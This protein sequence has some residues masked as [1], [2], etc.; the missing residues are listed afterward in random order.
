[1]EGKGR[2]YLVR[3][4]WEWW[5]ETRRAGLLSPLYYEASVSFRPVRLLQHTSESGPVAWPIVKGEM[6]NGKCLSELSDGSWRYR[7][8]VALSIDIKITSVNTGKR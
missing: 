7:L 4:E 1:M 6:G 3:A 8:G 2:S 5:P